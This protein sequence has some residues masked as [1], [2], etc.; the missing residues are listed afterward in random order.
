MLFNYLAN[1]DTNLVIREDI[2]NEG[3]YL[4]KNIPLYV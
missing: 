3:S 1:I 4:L 2:V